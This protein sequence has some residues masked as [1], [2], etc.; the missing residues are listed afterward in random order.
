MT[1]SSIRKRSP[2]RARSARS[3]VSSV[4]FT[5]AALYF[6]GLALGALGTQSSG[7][8]ETYLALYAESVLA[9]RIS[10]GFLMPA[11]GAFLA[12]ISLLIAA[13]IF[14]SSPF[15]APVILLLPAVKGVCI[16]C[17][18]A[19]LVAHGLRGAAAALVLFLFPEAMSAL[20]QIVFCAAALGQ[21]TALFSLHIAR[22]SNIII[23]FNDIFYLFT[24][25][26]AVVLVL[27]LCA[28]C[29]NAL[30]AQT[31]LSG[32]LTPA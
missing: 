15:G 4:Y 26:G 9:S 7:E 3:G 25:T 24:L 21:S 17:V 10:A 29:L 18:A 13:L 1:V 31:L 32:V 2:I 5:L 12:F 8:G 6:L 16:G 11:A 30:F 20:A 23:R 14:G 28:G 27:G 19:R 22:K